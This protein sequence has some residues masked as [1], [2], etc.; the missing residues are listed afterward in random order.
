[1][2]RKVTFLLLAATCAFIRANDENLPLMGKTY[3]APR[4]QSTNAALELAGF[5]RYINLYTPPV[6]NPCDSF[7]TAGYGAFAITPVYTHSFRPRRLAEYFFGTDELVISGSQVPGRDNSKQ[8]LADYFGLSPFY[9]STVRI[10]PEIRTL[11]VDFNLYWGWSDY[12]I[13]I[14]AP[15][16]NTKWDFQLYELPVSDPDISP[17][18]PP[19]YMAH[20]AIVAPAHSFK[21]ALAGNITYGDVKE[22]IQFGKVCGPRSASALSDVQIALGWNFINRP[23]GHCGFNIRGSIPTGTRPHG[24]FLFEPTVGNGHHWEL[25]LGFTGHLILWEKE[26]EHVIGIFSDVNITHLFSARQR[27]SFDLLPPFLNCPKI[28]N[29]RGVASRYMLMKEFDASGNYTGITIPVINRT[30]L[31]CKVRNDVEFD[32]VLMASYMNNNIGVDF[33]YN[34]W[35]RTREKIELLQAFPANTFGLK[36]IQNVATPTG[37]SNATQNTATIFGNDYADQALVAD[38]NPPVFISPDRIDIGSAATPFSFTHKFFGHV[39]Y[40]WD[41]YP[42]IEPFLGIGGEVEFEGLHPHDEAEPN[43]IAISQW[44]VWLKGGFGF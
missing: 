9:Q 37:L 21:Q 5:H 17:L 15:Y 18:F 13:R 2:I 32:I 24:E 19:L 4:S 7:F 27:R 26:N 8:I 38:P 14:H 6:C 35:I 10:V 20:D 43:K 22:G 31:E 1:M 16:V 39:N 41:C 25:G 30:T 3:L 42:T 29:F 36:G 28:E 40:S 33:G 34:A 44:G 23:I 12:Y 11:F